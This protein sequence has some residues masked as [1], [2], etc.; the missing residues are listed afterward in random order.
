MPAE[1][2][3][4]YEDKYPE[5]DDLVVVEVKSIAD[6]GAYVE[7]LE[8]NKIE[9]MIL[10]SELSRKRI[11]SINRLIR[12]GKQEVVLVLRVNK[13]KGYIDLSKRRVAREDIPKAEM[14]YV[15]S[16]TVHGIMRYVAERTDEKM[17]TLYEQIAWPLYKKYGHA[18]DAFTA[19]IKN[20]DTIFEGLNM[21]DQVRE[22]LMKNIKRRLTPQPVKIRSDFEVTCF[23]EKGIEAIKTALRAGLAVEKGDLQLSIKLVAPPLYVMIT[24]STEQSEGIDLLQRALNAVEETVRKDEGDLVIKIA[25]RVVSEQ[26][27]KRLTAHMEEL[28][29]LNKDRDGDDDYSESDDESD[30]EDDEE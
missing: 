22:F 17:E 25:P 1:P 4:M 18:Y 26:D 10:F 5:V 12:V 16:K 14:K 28:E 30:E 6:M 9:G 13:E 24:T 27:D 20:E 23:N 19:A 7:L 8:Y 11:R 21:S 15:K 3:R 2:C 29:R